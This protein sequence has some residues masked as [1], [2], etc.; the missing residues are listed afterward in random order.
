MLSRFTRWV[1]AALLLVACDERE[2]LTFPSNEPP[3]DI[4]SPITTIDHPAVD[5]VITEGDL[6]VLSGRTIDAT[7]VDTVYFLTRG[8]NQSF[9]PFAAGG[10]D[11]V[12]FGL[13]IS[14]IGLSNANV[15]IEIYGVD[16]EGHQGSHAIRR[17]TIE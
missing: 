7:G 6:V 13:P 8:T 16:L 14:T 5:S 17:L 9:H 10:E 3:G 1:G 2:R 4:V 12:T 11:T 15:T